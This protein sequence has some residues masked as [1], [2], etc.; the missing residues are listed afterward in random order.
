M[1]HPPPTCV[2]RLPACGSERQA[3]AE[4]PDAT[5]N[6]DYHPHREHRPHSPGWPRPVPAL[7]SADI[8]PASSRQGP[9][10]P[11][12]PPC[13]TA[14]RATPIPGVLCWDRKFHHERHLKRTAWR[15]D[16]LPSSN[17]SACCPPFRERR[18]KEDHQGGGTMSHN[19]IHPRPCSP[20]TA[21]SAPRCACWSAE[22]WGTVLTKC[23]RT[24]ARCH[25]PRPG[26]PGS[27]LLAD[28]LYWEPTGHLTRSRV[29]PQPGQRSRTHCGDG[30]TRP[31]VDEYADKVLHLSDGMIVE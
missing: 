12:R 16:H 20:L 23:R 4:P 29:L 18:A 14:G 15:R 1:V 11:G 2:A 19:Q 5:M 31:I 28:D 10:W 6:V 21:A 26:E 7:A 24:A 8:P 13:S 27:I 9:F 25:C 3:G 30:L 22:R 17:P